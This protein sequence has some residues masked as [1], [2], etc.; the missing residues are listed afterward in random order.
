ML[1]TE[2][3]STFWNQFCAKL[4]ILFIYQE[5][6]EVKAK[7]DPEEGESDY[8]EEPPKKRFDFEAFESS[9]KFSGDINL[10]NCVKYWIFSQWL[11]E[12]DTIT[13]SFERFKVQNL[14]D[15]TNK[16]FDTTP[17]YLQEIKLNSTGKSSMKGAVRRNSIQ[18]GLVYDKIDA[19]LLNNLFKQY[20]NMFTTSVSQEKL[21]ELRQNVEKQYS[22]LK[23]L[24]LNGNPLVLVDGKDPTLQTEV[25]SLNMLDMNPVSSIDMNKLKSKTESEG[26]STPG[27]IRLKTDSSFDLS[28]SVLGGINGVKLTEETWSN[29][30][31]FGKYLVI[32]LFTSLFRWTRDK[33]QKF[34]ILDSSRIFRRNYKKWCEAVGYR[35]H[36]G[37]GNWK[38][39]F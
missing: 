17:A 33:I 26:P 13:K 29:L 34:K 36:E 9:Q 10:C 20:P 28:I 3:A 27:E 25:P 16:A 6:E 11:Q 4:D 1:A 23:I 24:D 32:M 31:N 7:K 30:P 19:T 8:E 38:N 21:I 18:I 15:N 35:I 39:W 14:I 12:L 2:D 22:N 5:K 37:W